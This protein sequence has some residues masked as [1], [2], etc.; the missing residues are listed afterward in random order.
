MS[1]E[2]T[3]RLRTTLQIGYSTQYRPIY[4]MVT[5]NVRGRRHVKFFVAVMDEILNI[6]REVGIITDSKFTN[7][8]GSLI[9]TDA[10]CVVWELS[11]KVFGI[12]DKLTCNTLYL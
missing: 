8:F 7:D 11:A 1:E 6:T 9:V 3:N 12:G 4:A 10:D 2:I 5:K